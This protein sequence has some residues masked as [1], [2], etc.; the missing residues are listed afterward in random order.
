M[1]CFHF[2]ALFFQSVKAAPCPGASWRVMIH[3]LLKLDV[4]CPERS[5]PSFKGWKIPGEARSEAPTPGIGSSPSCTPPHTSQPGSFSSFRF[6]V[7]SCFLFALTRQKLPPFC[8]QGYLRMQGLVS[9]ESLRQ[10]RVENRLLRD[11]APMGRDLEDSSQQPGNQELLGAPLAPGP[12]AQS[13][14]SNKEEL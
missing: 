4:R 8:Q 14:D 2:G 7:E 3:D 10:H 1:V 12:L 6:C 9:T 11:D 13:L 5:A